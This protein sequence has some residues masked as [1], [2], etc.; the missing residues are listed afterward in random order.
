MKCIQCN[1]DNNLRDRTANQGRCQSCD[2][3]FVFEPTTM[4]KLKFT[5]PFFAK[6]ISDISANNTLYFT[7]KQF[8]YLLNRRLERKSFNFVGMISL[9]LFLSLWT[10]GFFGG[11]LSIAIGTVAFPL[12]LV[13]YNLA[14]IF[15]LFNL[16]NS[17]TSSY[18][19]R[20]SSAKG[21]IVLGTIIIV[22]GLLSSLNFNNPIG[23]AIGILM[24]GLAVR[25]GIVQQR[26]ALK[27]PHSFLIN[28]AQTNT[29]LNQWQR[30][31]GEVT[32][33]LT[34]Q[35]SL[36]KSD[37]QI[38][39]QPPDITA[40]SFDRLIV[41]E[42][43]EIAQMLIANNFHFEH[44]CAI[45]SIS[46]Y[47]QHLFETIMTMLRRNP[48]LKVFALHNCSPAGMR[49]IHQLRTDPS[50]FVNSNVTIIDIGLSPRQIIDA[51]KSMFVLNT[52]V[53]A[54]QAQKLNPEI[55]QNLSD[56]ELQWLDAGNFVELESFS[57]QKLIRILQRS[58]ANSEQGIYA[59]DNNL[60]STE[61]GDGADGY[62]FY[63]IDSFG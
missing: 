35:P 63:A 5:D 45:L 46:G 13:L 14:C 18:K 53:S 11:F 31:N 57:V 22:V 33:M 21:L 16:S 34:S 15:Y 56:E 51:G 2:H 12:V 23:F 19:T 28:M 32:L 41:C 55:R 27:I 43:D 47:P 48:E 37:P 25:M 7:P 62:L 9:Y 17:E 24:G 39:N 20:Q 59:E 10:T 50:W 8:L 42:S 29:W 1:T 54:K 58:I 38:N 3:P 60:L 30:A 40:Y 49:I 6:L 52:S 4:G 36:L 44:N 61:S 26:K